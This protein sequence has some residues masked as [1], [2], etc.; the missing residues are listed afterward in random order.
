MK[1]GETGTGARSTRP[2]AT[3]GTSGSS[4]KSSTKPYRDVNPPYFF[5]PYKV[6]R[7]RSPNEPL[8]ELPGWY[9]ASRG[10]DTSRIPYDPADNDL[11]HRFTSPPI[12]QLIVLSGRVLDRAGD[13]VPGALIEIWQTNGAGA[14]ADETDPGFNPQDPNFVGWGRARTDAEG[15]YVF[16]TLKPAAYPG[17]LGGLYRPSHIHLSVFGPDLQSRIITQCY[18]EG[19]PLVHRDPIVQSVQ[20]RAGIERLQA[21]FDSEATEPGGIGSAL[22][23]TYDIV[24]R[25]TVRAHTFAGV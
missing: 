3:G 15:R 18:F 13:P 20:D 25:G 24:L 16:R 7:H 22:A 10:P 21:R 4:S 5:E 11:I 8:V 14:Y 12:G 23:Y 9:A 17:S 6:T 2:A 19:D 1:R